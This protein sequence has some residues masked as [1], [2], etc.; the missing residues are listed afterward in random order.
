MLPLLLYVPSDPVELAVKEDDTKKRVK[1]VFG[2]WGKDS[3]L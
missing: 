1:E 2:V 3:A